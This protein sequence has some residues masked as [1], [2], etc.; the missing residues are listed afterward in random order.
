MARGDQ[1]V[2][3]TRRYGHARQALGTQVDLVEGDPM[4]PGEWMARVD[5]CDAV[6]RRAQKAGATIVRPPSDA[7]YGERS[8]RIRDPFGHEWLIGHHIEDV[9]PEEMQKRYEAMTKGATAKK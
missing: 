1:A 8:G 4:A 9:T 7:F 2:V 5:D 3:L 6:I